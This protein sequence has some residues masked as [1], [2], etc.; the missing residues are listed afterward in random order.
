MTMSCMPKLR[1]LPSPQHARA[2]AAA[3]SASLHGDHVA[4]SKAAVIFSPHKPKNF[5]AGVMRFTLELHDNR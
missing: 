3:Q 5:A 4:W 1:S 2:G